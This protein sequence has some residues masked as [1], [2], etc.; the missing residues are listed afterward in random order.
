MD[1]RS[2]GVVTEAHFILKTTHKY[3]QLD[4]FF[5]KSSFIFDI[6]MNCAVLKEASRVISSKLVYML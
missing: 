2:D 1:I 4:L 6:I 3:M 5:L